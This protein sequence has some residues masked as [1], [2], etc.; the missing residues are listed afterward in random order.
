MYLY[1]F[2]FRQYFGK[3]LRLWM[4]QLIIKMPER[5]EISLEMINSLFVQGILTIDR[6][7]I[8]LF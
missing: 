6:H 3:Y 1:R 4:S 7:R 5:H 2:K 8:S